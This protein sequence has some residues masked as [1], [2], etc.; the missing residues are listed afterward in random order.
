M[1]RL[2]R[3]SGPHNDHRSALRSVETKNAST[4]TSPSAPQGQRGYGKT[5]RRV[6]RQSIQRHIDRGHCSEPIEVHRAPNSNLSRLPRAN[7]G[8]SRRSWTKRLRTKGLATQSLT[9]RRKRLQNDAN[10]QKLPPPRR[11][12]DRRTVTQ[13]LNGPWPRSRTTIAQGIRGQDAPNRHVQRYANDPA[14][15]GMLARSD[16]PP[17]RRDHG[18]SSD[19]ADFLQERD[20]RRLVVIAKADKIYRDAMSEKDYRTALKAGG[21]TCVSTASQRTRLD[22]VVGR[23]ANLDRC[24]QG[25]AK[26]F[27]DAFDAIHGALVAEETRKRQALVPT[28]MGDDQ[29]QSDAKLTSPWDDLT[30]RHGELRKV[31]S[32]HART[33]A[34]RAVKDCQLHEFAAKLRNMRLVGANS[35]NASPS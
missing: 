20:R 5:V 16:L 7:P 8:Q 31:A 9:L 10:L 18:A 33:N 13:H 4:S 17:A 30:E 12:V 25:V 28:T 1:A 2:L 32:C 22:R 6:S 26:R 34:C 23:V 29:R 15:K 21:S 24:S 27:P 14:P 19:G 11:I 3:V 35:K